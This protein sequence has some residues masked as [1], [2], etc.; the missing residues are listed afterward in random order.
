[1]IARAASLQCWSWTASVMRR[2]LPSAMTA[3][4]GPKQCSQNIQKNRCRTTVAEPI[5]ETLAE[6]PFT[7][8][9]AVCLGHDQAAWS[10]PE[11]Q[12]GQCKLRSVD[13]SLRLEPRDC[14]VVFTPFAPAL[15]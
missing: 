9:R 7:G 2:F 1:M 10:G 13:P 8:D 11:R 4:S 3:R 12:Q 15:L 5:G 6:P 14:V